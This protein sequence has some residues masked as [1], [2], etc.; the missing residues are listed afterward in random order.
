MTTLG[1]ILAA[2]SASV[3]LAGWIVAKRVPPSTVEPLQPQDDATKRTEGPASTWNRRLAT[4]QGL[5][6]AQD[7]IGQARRLEGTDPCADPPPLP[8]SW[9]TRRLLQAIPWTIHP[10]GRRRLEALLDDL[11]ET[12]HPP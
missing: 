11:D 9:L 7:L 3:S 8:E 5:K 2:A 10:R 4:P 12:E 6:D 1:P